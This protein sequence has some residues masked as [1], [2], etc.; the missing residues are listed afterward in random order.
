MYIADTPIIIYIHQDLPGLG[1]CSVTKSCLTLCDPMDWNVCSPRA[2]GLSAVA[3]ALIT[4]C[5]HRKGTGWQPQADPFLPLSWTPLD[6]WPWPLLFAHLP[7]LRVLAPV[8]PDT[9][10]QESLWHTRILCPP[11][12]P[13]V[14]SNSHPLSR[15]CYLTISSFTA[16]FSFCLQSFPASRSFPLSQLFASRGQSVGASALASVIPMNI[17]GWF[18]SGLTGLIFFQSKDFPGGSVVKN[19]SVNAGDSRNMGSIPG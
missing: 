5:L 3:W 6:S 11:L 9:D 15:W 14:C 16:L 18:P 17:Q 4:L 7:P 1:C 2:L 10:T 8:S 19:L 12:S 13:R